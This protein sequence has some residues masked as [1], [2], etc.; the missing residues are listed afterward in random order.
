MLTPV[1]HG[2]GLPPAFEM[3]MEV[4]LPAIVT[5]TK[6]WHSSFMK[7]MHR[8]HQQS[9]NIDRFTN[10][11]FIPNS[12]KLKFKLGATEHLRETLEFKMLAD[13][14]TQKVEEFQS[15]LKEDI[16]QAAE[17]ELKK[18]MDETK[19]LFCKRHK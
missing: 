19:C 11:T 5:L 10:D 13:L 16:K 9:T 18:I 15:K 7:L 17:L 12:A 14:T 6:F 3:A 8:A 2:P 1:F 4:L